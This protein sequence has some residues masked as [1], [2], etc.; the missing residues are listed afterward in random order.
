MRKA[1]VFATLLFVMLMGLPALAKSGL[2]GNSLL[3][4]CTTE[5]EIM[6]KGEDAG[7][8]PETPHWHELVGAMYCQGLVRGVAAA[9]SD[10]AE[11]DGVT[12]GQEIRIVLLYLQT[13]PEE[14]QK[15]DYAL[16]HE[17]LRKAFPAK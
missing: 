12:L 15:P 3:P 10:F 14:L 8:T 7:T 6:D 16:V 4:K 5:V 13:H 17:A 11:P 2:D 9:S 1:G